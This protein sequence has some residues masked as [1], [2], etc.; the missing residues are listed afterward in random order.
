[1]KSTSKANLVKLLDFLGSSFRGGTDVTGPLLRAIDLLEQ[2]S[3]WASADLLLVTDGELQMPP[4]EKELMD[5]LARMEAERGLEIHGLLVGRNSSPPLS[6]LCTDWDGVD[7]VYDFLCKYDP[8]TVLRQQQLM[9]DAGSD[10][11]NVSG[12]YITETSTAGMDQQIFATASSSRLYAVDSRMREQQQSSLKNKFRRPSAVIVSDI[13]Q[14]K[15]H[16]STSSSSSSMRLFAAGTS[17]GDVVG[18]GFDAVETTSR[19]AKETLNTRLSAAVESRKL[20]S[21][22]AN[23]GSMRTMLETILTKLSAGLVERE[24]EVKLLL[25]SALCREHILLLGP[26]GTG[27]L[28]N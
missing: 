19:S 25:L 21:M 17:I 5:K 6:M 10:E 12:M 16:R 20:A 24:V 1:L 28:R 7:R 2:E 4:I 13:L 14:G 27:T 8:L 9:R 18:D 22:E 11:I 3:E 15:R 26:P 23:D